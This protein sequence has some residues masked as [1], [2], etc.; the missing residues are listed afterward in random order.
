MT[1]ETFTALCHTTH[2]HVQ[3]SDHCIE[4]LGAKYVLFGKFQT[5]CLEARFGQYRQLAGGN[6]DVSLRQIYEY[7]KKIRLLSVLNLQVNGKK[8]SLTNFAINWDEFI[9]DTSSESKDMPILISFEEW[10]NAMQY[11]PVITY[12]AGYCAFFVSKKLKCEECRE[13]LTSTVGE[14][15]AIENELIPKLTRGR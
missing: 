11:L 12:I 2:A 5:D 8:V 7:E 4:E 13:R 15:Y 14:I 1:K 10:E 6:Y 9:E 3:I